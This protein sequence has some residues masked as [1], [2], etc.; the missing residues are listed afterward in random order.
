MANGTVI[1]AVVK[2]VVSGGA[3]AGGTTSIPFKVAQSAGNA[4]Q[5][6][7]KSIHTF[8]KAQNRPTRFRKKGTK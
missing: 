1:G 6:I 4:I 3:K 8:D 5:G 7:K 2:G